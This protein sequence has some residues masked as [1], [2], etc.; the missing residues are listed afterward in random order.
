MKCSRCQYQNPTDTH[1]CGQCGASMD[2]ESS[3]TVTW[4]APTSRLSRGSLFAS[5]YEVIEEIGQGGMGTVYRVYD[6]KVKEQIAIKLIKPAVAFDPS[7]LERFNNEVKIARKVIHKNVCRMYDLSESDGM[8]FITMEHVSGEDLS[9]LIKRIGQLSTKK[10]VAITKQI[11]E[12]LAEAHSLGIIHRDLKPQNV[13]LDKQGNVRIMDFGI[14]RSLFTKGLTE[15]GML[16]GTPEYMSPEQVEGIV[17]DERSDIYSL[18]V[19]LFEMLTGLVPFDGNTPMSIALKHMT[20]TPANPRTFNASIPEGLN[21]LVLKCMEKD[22]DKRYRTAR[23]VIDELDQLEV[24]TPMPERPSVQERPSTRKETVQK[25]GSK[26]S[27]VAV[28]GLL[29]VAAIAILLWQFVFKSRPVETAPPPLPP[30]LEERL[31]RAAVLT[32]AGQLQEALDHLA[33]ILEQEPQHFEALLLKAEIRADQGREEDAITAYTNLIDL[34]ARDPRAYLAL[35]EISESRGD[36][37]AA[38]AHFK[39]YIQR[40]PPGPDASRIE[41]VI[42]DLEERLRPEP[43]IQPAV[44]KAAPEPKRETQADRIRKELSLAQQDFDSGR[45][46]DSLTRLSRVLSLDSQNASAL[47][48]RGRTQTTLDERAINALV[49]LY[50]QSLNQNRLVDFYR[51]HGTPEFFAEIKRDAELITGQYQSFKSQA[52][53]IVVTGMQ[54]ASTQVA[55]SHTIVGVSKEDGSEQVIF[56]GGYVWTLVKIAESWKISAL[57]VRTRSNS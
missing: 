36:L 51:E 55:F 6:Q 56:E 40:A 16:M 33:S 14:A 15:T 32:E 38:L 41:G 31:S 19:I 53:Q 1:F 49:G 17:V 3:P 4:Q 22:P 23:E 43:E 24:G 7:I 35:G 5:R 42:A 46:T 29:G 10:A 54:G 45:F 27:L 25:P 50:V 52:D 57:R 2:P 13:M 30:T 9:S 12:G 47:E 18:G 37:E 44:K 26:K 39:D 21:R 34:D 48:L 11:S 28:F 8:H 20:H